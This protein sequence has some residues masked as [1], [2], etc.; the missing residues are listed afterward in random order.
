MRP[1]NLETVDISGLHL[2][3]ASAGT[4]KTWT[5]A[6]LYILLLLEKELR[7]EQI[8]VVTY[9]KAATSEL[10]DR[11]R[12]RIRTTLDLFNG[13]RDASDDRL[14]QILLKDRPQN[15]ERARL[16]L[17]RALYSFDDA[18]I[19]T[20]HGFCQRALLENA[21]ESGSLFDTEMISDQSAIVRQVCDDFWRAYLPHQSDDFIENL[22]NGSFN[23]EKLA[24]PF[25]GYYQNSEIKIIP[26]GDDSNL[27]PLITERNALYADICRIW[28]RE[29]SAILEQLEQAG[30]H[31]GSYSAKQIA[32][33]AET[34]NSWVTGSAANAPCKRLEFFSIGKIRS[35]STKTT[36]LIPIHAF[37]ESCQLMFDVT[38]ALD[39]ACREKLIACRLNLK[40]W[41]EKELPLRKKSLNQRCFDD[42]LMDLHLA[43]EAESGRV[44]ASRLRER[45]KAA[46]IDEFQDTD[47]LQW[48]I[49][50]KLLNPLPSK[51]GE[52]DYP[53]FL[54]GDP[55]QAIYSFRG[56]D[57]FAYLN[58]ASSIIAEKRQTLGTNFRSAPSLVSAVN[59]LFSADPDPFRCTDIP[60]NR[61]NSGRSPADALLHDASP[62]LPPLH[63]WI[64]PREDE[65]KAEAKPVATS[66]TVRAVAAEIARLLQ[67]G[68]YRIVSSGTERPLSPEDIAV[69]V[70][71][72][73]QA[74]S[75]QQALQEIG[76]PSVQHGGATVFNSGEA[77]DLLRILRAIAE[78]GRERLLREA[79]LTPTI[80]L[81]ASEIAAFVDSSGDRP[82]WEMWLLRFRDLGFAAH[83]GGII[84]MIGRLLGE[85]GLRKELLSR[86]GGERSLTNI[87]HCTELLHQ[88]ELEH[89]N[90]LAGAISWLERRISG[91]RKDDA[92]LLRLE[93]DDNAV[94]ISTI[95]ASKGLEYPVVF[96]PFAWDPPSSR[97]WR[98]MYHDSDGKL[99]LD[100]A[101][102][103]EHKKLAREEQSA[104]AA[105]LLYVALTRA[106]FRCYFV[107][108][109]ING[110]VESPLFN[111]LHGDN[112]SKTF[113]SMTDRAI[114]DDVKS[115]AVSGSG[116]I[117]AEM[118]P[119]ESAAFR[120]QGGRERDKP[121]ICRT[122]AQQPLDNWRVSSFSSILSGIGHFFQ[123]RDYDNLP[124]TETTSVT[125]VPKPLS[126]EESIFEFPRGVKAGTCLHEIFEQ[127][128]FAA[129][130]IDDIKAITAKTLAA[131]GFYD[132]WLPA[133]SCMISNATSASIIR[134]DP[135]F[136]L[137][138]LEKGAWQTEM[139]FYLPIIQLAPDTL[140]SL[141]D[142]L[143]DEGL[144]A[145]FH[146]VLKA[147]LFKRCRGMLQG[148]IDLVFVHEERYYLLDWKSNH[149]GYS[150]DDY[151]AGRMQEA[152]SLSAYI[153]QYHLYTL[154]L[155]RLLKQRLPG[156]DY[157]IHFGG[158]IYL[159][160]RG[161]S[162]ADGAAGIYHARPSPEFIRRANDLM[163]GRGEDIS[164]CHFT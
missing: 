44:L 124:V 119:E 74:S 162:D 103:E 139:E 12:R 125:S 2:I 45:Y 49:F 92:A 134:D 40:T 136:C 104:E 56:A 132:R 27:F 16:L 148:F 66:K 77:L 24:K 156:Y 116:G 141:F 111:L 21:F 117:V 114:L 164:H 145:D 31:Q 98:V 38:E 58:A 33:A 60:F 94:R 69:L 143:L 4:G 61:V 131:N 53:L 7:P 123:P 78:P 146:E 83:S 84:A 107:W 17:T 129:L 54:I 96:L 163:L 109:C 97:S 26:D 29:R 105:R 102:E 51:E 133:V 79:L 135:G 52:R 80:G 147:L 20:I 43:L 30:L 25:D 42:L 90:G 39:K 121:Y 108:G 1:L 115:L 87:L 8:L 73:K 22:V 101:E 126:D 95:H 19:F 35:K 72:H 48:N 86:E 82:E 70:K 91:D 55:K 18:A 88:A 110:A 34:L 59:T 71:S 46:L 157:E 6:A 138:K 137:S 106:E 158:A 37:F 67:Q 9:T 28:K 11:I 118:M 23:P 149:L 128:D 122:V 112:L 32:S 41:L 57:L 62:P 10:R 150:P 144:F 64:Y 153:L 13:E 81:T 100:L 99:V 160:L 14:E 89:C 152:M 36:R 68:R 113:S 63:V 155:D 120:Y 151:G 47:P 65:S 142:G 127:L 15:P 130:R 159:F 140:R 50:K 93:T 5:I 161:V 154:A 75:V 76:I 85:C 3:E